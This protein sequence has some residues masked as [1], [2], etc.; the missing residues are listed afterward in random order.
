MAKSTKTYKNSRAKIKVPV[1]VYRMLLLFSDVLPLLLL[2][3]LLLLLLLFIIVHLP[4]DL[5]FI[6]TAL[7]THCHLSFVSNQNT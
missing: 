2:Q 4:P 1:C 5:L 6:Q 3:L 7:L